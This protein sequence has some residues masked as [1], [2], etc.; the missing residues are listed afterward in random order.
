[1]AKA[2]LPIAAPEDF[3][4]VTLMRMRTENIKRVRLV[5]I[6]LT[7]TLT[8]IGGD[9][10]NGKTSFLDGYDWCLSGNTV[11]QMDPIH[12]G[13]Q[14]GSILCEFGDGDKV[15][16]AVTRTLLRVGESS[17]TSDL[18]IHIPGHLAPTR[19]QEFLDKLGGRMSFDPMSFDKLKD[20]ERVE[21]MRKLVSGFDFDANA[22]ARKVAFD[23]RTVVKRDRDRERSAVASIVI[24]AEAPHQRVDEDE[25][26]VRLQEGGKTNA[27]RERRQGVRDRAVE[28]IRIARESI[29]A[30]DEA[31]ATATQN[32]IVHRDREVARLEAQIAAIRTQIETTVSGCAQVIANETAALRANAEKAAGEADELQKRLDAAPELP[33]EVDTAA[34][35]A[36]LSAGRAT[37][38]VLTDWESQRERRNE[39]AL[40]AS[41]LDDQA[42]VL[43]AEI[44]ALDVARQA[45]IAAANLP[46]EGIGFGDGY[47]TLNG[48]PW[49][50]AGRAERVD[51]ST[52]IAM[53]LNPKLRVILIRD[54]SDLGS[55]MKERIRQRAA[56]MGYRVLMEVADDTGSTHVVIEDGLV[57]AAGVEQEASEAQ[58]PNGAKAV[59]SNGHNAG[60]QL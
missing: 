55:K 39:H 5:D 44:E 4:G 43:T 15:S 53:A 16:L 24:S 28:T 6:T 36:T 31:I 32:A 29:V 52:A 19:V 49:S 21:A 51:A 40:K 20:P 2:K 59:V 25:L 14:Q 12:H 56:T 9:N 35:A 47:I 23:K 8:L 41:T 33:V 27:D 48:A 13:K 26:T 1:M 60:A 10:S 50:Q 54:G 45:A 7:E 11:I 37:N 22:A 30:L 3:E 58:A 46:V 18:D 34:L 42:T 17:W 38:K 57:K